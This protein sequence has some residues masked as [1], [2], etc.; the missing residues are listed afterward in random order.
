M[1]KSML[2]EKEHILSAAEEN[3]LAQ[4]SEITGATNDVFKMLNNADMTFGL[5]LI[6][7]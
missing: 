1:L 3:I 7:I 4:M 6:H 2:R 5:S